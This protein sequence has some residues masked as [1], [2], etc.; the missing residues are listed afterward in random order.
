MIEWK[1]EVKREI[2]YLKNKVDG[3]ER[4]IVEILGVKEELLRI[5]RQKR[6][7]E[8]KEERMQKRDDRKE[9]DIEHN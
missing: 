2:R 4:K 9:V 6:K 1:R 3:L 5:G 7:K 8:K